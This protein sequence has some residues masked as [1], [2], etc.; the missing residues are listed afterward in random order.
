MALTNGTTL[1]L[2]A[3]GRPELRSSGIFAVNDRGNWSVTCTS[4][5]DNE[6]QASLAAFLCSQLGFIDYNNFKVFPIDR[7]RNR[8]LQPLSNYS[9]FVQVKGHEDCTVFYV[10]CVTE[11][12]HPKLE[13]P[14]HTWDILEEQFYTPWIARIYVNGSYQCAG[15]LIDLSWVLTST[16][17]FEHQLQ[18][19]KNS[20]SLTK[21]LLNLLLEI[22]AF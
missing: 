8:I 7:V 4:E 16:H 18:Y 3:D 17:C 6:K 9:T 11:I 22:R 15:V 5:Q 1:I 20:L 14:A 12:T 2:D 19:I 21:Q 13:Q 10:K